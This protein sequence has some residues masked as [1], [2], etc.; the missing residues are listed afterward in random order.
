M[1]MT[2]DIVEFAIKNVN[3]MVSMDL[4]WRCTYYSNDYTFNMFNGN[5]AKEPTV[6]LIV[7]TKDKD[8]V[9]LKKD[10]LNVFDN[11]PVIESMNLMNWVVKFYTKVKGVN[12]E[13]LYE[14]LDESSVG[15]NDVF[16]LCVVKGTKVTKKVKRLKRYYESEKDYEN[17]MNEQVNGTPSIV[18]DQHTFSALII[19]PFP[20]ESNVKFEIYSSGVVNVAGIPDDHYFSKIYEYINTDLREKFI[21]CTN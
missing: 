2:I 8:V 9:E 4:P 21:L 5:K 3:A 13:M 6:V 17:V 15:D 14:I 19:Q 20:Q 10:I 1:K 12:L 11:E 18:M 16:D 7:F